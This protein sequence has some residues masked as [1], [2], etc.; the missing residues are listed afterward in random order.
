MR[1]E[2]LM[3]SLNN[4]LGLHRLFRSFI[5]CC[6]HFLFM[7]QEKKRLEKILAMCEDLVNQNKKKDPT[8]DKNAEFNK[9]LMEIKFFGKGL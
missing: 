9:L 3:T 6:H 5:C 4:L 1:I 2:M 8:S 7:I